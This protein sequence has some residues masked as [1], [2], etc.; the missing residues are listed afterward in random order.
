MDA[1]FSKFSSAISKRGWGVG[2]SAFL[3]K[4]S[5]ATVFQNGCCLSGNATAFGEIIRMTTCYSNSGCAAP[6]AAKKPRQPVPYPIYGAQTAG[7]IEAC[8]SKFSPAFFKRGCGAV[9]SAF[10]KKDSLAT[11]FQNGC[12]LSGNAAPSEEIVQVTGCYSNSGCTAPVATNS[13]GSPCHTRYTGHRLPGPIFAHFSKF[14]PAF[15]KRRWGG[16]N[17]AFLKMPWQQSFRTVVA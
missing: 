15:S 3:K 9:N 12:C 1:C 11:V 2:N 14:S 5:L 10:L 8:F 7:P 13:P 17:S 6:V 4:D 16:V